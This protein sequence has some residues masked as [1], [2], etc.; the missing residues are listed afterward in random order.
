M[1]P[2]KELF[3]K[4]FSQGNFFEAETIA[5]LLVSQ[6]TEDVE[7]W[8]AL[9]LAQASQGKAEDAVN[10]LYEVCQ[11]RTPYFNPA[12]ELATKLCVENALWDLGVTPARHLVKLVPHS[13]DANF[14]LGQIC[15]NSFRHFSAIEA[16]KC[17]WSINPQSYEAASGL[18][19][20]LLKS[21][22]AN[23]GLEVAREILLKWPDS[24]ETRRL[25]CVFGN[26]DASLSDTEL[27][28]VHQQFGD[29]FFS[30]S[31]PVV[32]ETVCD[33]QGARFVLGVYSG[34]FRTHSVSYFLEPILA[35]LD[36][37]KWKLVGI[38][39]D[40]RK[41]ETTERLRSYFDEFIEA[42]SLS[43]PELVRAVESLSLD[44]FLDIEGLF[45]P[46]REAL[47]NSRL[48]DVYA[49]YLG[50]PN[51]TGIPVMDFRLTD[52]LVDKAGEDDQYYAEELKF[53]SRSFLCY[54]PPG[55]APEVALRDDSSGIVFGS[56]N[57]F[58]KFNLSVFQYWVELLK[59]VEGAVL[60]IKAI[61]VGDEALQARLQADFEEQGID[62]E[63]VRF[64]SMTA[65]THDHLLA[66]A[67]IDLHLDTFP[68]N[69]VTTTFEALWQGV[70]TLA[71]K[72]DNHRSR[73]AASINVNAGLHEF[74]ADDQDGLI[75]KAKFWGANVAEL[76]RRRPEYR[77]LLR[78]SC[79]MDEKAF[80]E[81]FERLME[82]LIFE[83]RIQN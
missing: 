81:D 28:Q 48:A 31:E 42:F 8:W 41:D 20:S 19:M 65:S 6:S 78:A 7:A 83:K 3:D 57:S 37:S 58:D 14:Y 71:L 30:N 35:N 61:A 52:S 17:A 50:Y 11:K 46:V 39:I 74:V 9:A 16:F 13:Y 76:R 56:F 38:N 1:H 68:F 45:A 29:S 67:C 69:G 23:Q 63:R 82:S 2:S 79:L 26:Y 5:R 12:V 60:I 15:R 40:S 80:T 10:S 27:F 75:R 43:D 36:R 73:V 4:Y 55:N 66:Y 47:F 70:P 32:R 54:R 25:L 64:M 18:M 21:G 34:S 24:K 49:T 44:V 77:D 72:G 59:Q 22:A 51:T 33:V 53:F 62:A